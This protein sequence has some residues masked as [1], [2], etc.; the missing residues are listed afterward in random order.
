MTQRELTLQAAVRADAKAAY[1]RAKAEAEHKPHW[2]RLADNYAAGARRL[3]AEAEQEA[4][5]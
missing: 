5:R 3:R 2:A 1:F 4:R